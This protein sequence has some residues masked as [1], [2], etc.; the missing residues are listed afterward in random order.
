MSKSRNN[1]KTLSLLLLAPFL[2]GL[3]TYVGIAIMRNTVTADITDIRWDYGDNEGFQVRS[4]TYPLKA[5]AVY[6]PEIKLASGNDLVWSVANVANT[7]EKVHASVVKDGDGFALSAL[8]EGKVYVVCANRRQ[9]VSKRFMANIYEDGTIIINPTHKAS[10]SSLRTLRH[11]GQYDLAYEKLGGTLT[12]KEA[13]FALAPQGFYEGLSSSVILQ[14][15]T[16]NVSYEGGAVTIKGVGEASLTFSLLEHPFVTS[17]YSFYVEE[18]AANIYSYDDL[19][20]ATNL[21]STG[22]PL[23][24]QKNLLSLKRTY[25]QDSGG[26]YTNDLLDSS[27]QLFGDYDF[28]NQTLSY[29]GQYADFVSTYPH[30]FL[31]K[32]NASASEKDQVSTHLKAA[33]RLRN[34]LFG[35]GFTLSFHELAYPTHGAVDSSGILTPDATKDYF[36]GPLP[37]FAIGSPKAPLIAAYGQ[38]NVGLLLDGD[39][40]TL[41]DVKIENTDPVDN[42]YDLD[43][44]GTVVE[45][46]GK[47]ATIANS[48]LSYGKTIVRAFGADGLLIKNSL[49][50]YGREF[51]LHLGSNN[52]LAPDET[53]SVSVPYR[54]DLIEASFHDFF[55]KMD[56]GPLD[57]DGIL[58][59]FVENGLSSSGTAGALTTLR[60]I[61]SS[62]DNDTYPADTFDSKVTLDGAKFAH[63]GIFSLALD[64]AFDGPYLYN[65]LPSYVSSKLASFLSGSASIPDHLGATSAPVQVTLKGSTG[66]YD[67]KDVAS[68]D[69][70]CLIANGLPAAGYSVKVSSFFP[71]ASLLRDVSQDKGLLYKTGDKEYLN[72][73]VAYYGGGL[74][75]S[76]VLDE[77]G[78]LGTAL[79]ASLPVDFLADSL[80]GQHVDTSQKAFLLMSRCVNLALGFHPFTFLTNPVVT[81][82]PPSFGVT[83]SLVAAE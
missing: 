48:V 38:D 33:V 65:G 47:N 72:S 30:S 60:A 39:N 57:A 22:L 5:T 16:P 15:T 32:W 58:T 40:L 12:K 14:S 53:K 64:A 82:T 56:Q 27:T 62:L 80:L 23:C 3:L 77:R 20:M 69:P 1:T 37:F 46:L 10:G 78:G 21:S 24:L 71:M 7:D 25:A 73:A 61:Q 79:G 50:Q 68:V 45:V 70:S 34:N 11:Y 76:K 28:K 2:V 13:R 4:S 75:R 42:F 43:Y 74:N 54:G 55:D 29:E 81:G 41:D 9:T 6:D 35:N 44:T 17:T 51:L 18:G 31:D 66:F 36:H 52:L 8:S 83:P 63:S 59:S 67:W 49:L 26:H 19:L